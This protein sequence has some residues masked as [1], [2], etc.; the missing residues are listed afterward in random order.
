MRATLD[1]CVFFAST[2]AK[3]AWLAFAGW[4]AAASGMARLPPTLT[5][6]TIVE[7]DGE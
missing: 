1:V 7:S 6:A 3:K 4:G 5:S 2:I